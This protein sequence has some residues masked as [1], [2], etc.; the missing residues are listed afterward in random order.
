M[1]SHR[2]A[3]ALARAC[4][5]LRNRARLPATPARFPGRSR[6]TG[7]RSTA[8]R[9]R[10][11][12]EM[13]CPCPGR[14]LREAHPTLLC[15]TPRDAGEREPLHVVS[16]PSPGNPQIQQILIQTGVPSSLKSPSRSPKCPC[17]SAKS[18]PQPRPPFHFPRPPRSAHPV[19]PCPR[20]L[21]QLSR[22][23]LT[24]SLCL[25]RAHQNS[26]LSASCGPTAG[27]GERS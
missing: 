26:P 17:H 11:R 27:T 3:A 23:R 14:T 12:L 22:H 15:F 16:R 7:A 21:S 10:G 9:R 5:T 20:T 25:S 19:R 13:G 1:A 24:T 2:A 4:R 18:P 8:P 6:A